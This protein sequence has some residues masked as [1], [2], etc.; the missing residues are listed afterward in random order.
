LCWC[1]RRRQVHDRHSENQKKCIGG[2]D[3]D[4]DDD[5]G[6]GGMQWNWMLLT[7]SARFGIEG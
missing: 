2:Y 4:H 7:L 5:V 6:G 3:D 1:R